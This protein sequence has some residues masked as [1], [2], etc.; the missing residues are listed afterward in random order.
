MYSVGQWDM[1]CQV[2]LK[3]SLWDNTVSCFEAS[4][5]HNANMGNTARTRVEF[6]PIVSVNNDMK[7]DL[8]AALLNSETRIVYRQE[9]KKRRPG[10]VTCDSRT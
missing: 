2:V 1:F 5:T 7:P 6:V 8:A 4:M 3:L 10:D 9:N